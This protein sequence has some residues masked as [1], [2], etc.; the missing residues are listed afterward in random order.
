[1]RTQQRGLGQRTEPRNGTTNMS[2][3]QQRRYADRMDSRSGHTTAVVEPI[4]QECLGGKISVCVL[5]YNHGHLIQSTLRSVLNQTLVNYEVVVS[6]DCSS[7]DT[8]QRILEIAAEDSRV[9]AIRT[10]RNLGMPG[11]ANFAIAQVSRPYI[12]LLHH[13]DLYR[14]DL[15]EKWASVLERHADVGF[16]FNAYGVFESDF[17][18]HEPLAEER[19]DGRWLLR[20]YLLPRWGCPVRGTAMIRR[21]AWERVAGMREHFG[22]LADVDLWMRLARQWQV[23]Y[24]NEPVITVR[25]D[26]PKHYPSIYKGE[27]WSWRRQRYLYEIHA[28]NRLELLDL[29]RPGPRLRWLMFRWHLSLETSKW[30]IYGVVRRKHE[31]LA[32]CQ[33]SATPYD[34]WPLR[35]FRS[36]LLVALRLCKRPMG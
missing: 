30:L 29:K 26:W 31:I 6:D 4:M 35:V 12:A 22:L 10:P 8:W 33:D 25:Q 14:R 9:K 13:D 32:S 36:V 34:L 16:V 20:H 18:Y 28:N 1:M 27:T 15:L 2:E 23:G 21:L 19:I 7:D 17:V 11:N 24:V 3:T 5:T